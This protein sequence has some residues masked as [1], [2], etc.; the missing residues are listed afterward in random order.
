VQYT[1]T[2]FKAALAVEAKADPNGSAFNA[3]LPTVIDQAEGLIYRTP[4]L[5][6]L[7]TIQTD[8]TGTTTPNSREFVLPRVFAVLQSVN[9]V[10]GN[11]RPPL[12]KISREA[13]D[14]LYPRAVAVDVAAMPTKWAPLTDQTILLGPCPGGA[15]QLVCVGEVTPAPLSSGNPTTWLSTYLGDLFFAAAMIFM[16]GYQGN[17]GAQADNPQMAVSWK[18]IF[19]TLLPGALGQEMRRKYASTGGMA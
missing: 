19:E 18:A 1:Y 12:T 4:G 15:V 6:F 10:A 8:S 5:E 2:S 11:D 3:I 16:T 14:A 7:A 9:R 17:F 13:M